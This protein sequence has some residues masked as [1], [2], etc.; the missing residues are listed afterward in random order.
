MI[1]KMITYSIFDF[2]GIKLKSHFGLQKK[3]QPMNYN[4]EIVS[5]VFMVDLSVG[6]LHSPLIIWTQAQKKVAIGNVRLP[7][8]Y[9]WLMKGIIWDCKDSNFKS[10]Q[11]HIKLECESCPGKKWSNFLLALITKRIPFHWWGNWCPF[12]RTIVENDQVKHIQNA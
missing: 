7:F 1:I 2:W 6:I 11:C 3:Q 8:S 4:G 12:L 9:D 10:F 5:L